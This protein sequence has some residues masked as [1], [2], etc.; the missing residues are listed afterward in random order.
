VRDHCRT[1]LPDEIAVAAGHAA[2]CVLLKTGEVIV[3]GA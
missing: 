3:A 1:A 2:R